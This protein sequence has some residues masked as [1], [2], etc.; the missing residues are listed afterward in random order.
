[1]LQ[2][3]GALAPPLIVAVAFI[4]G[5][6]FLLHRELAPKRRRLEDNEVT[7]AT[8]GRS[9]VGARNDETVPERGEASET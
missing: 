2:D 7:V 1:M 8:Q 9:A 3:L 4:I 6:G 5:V